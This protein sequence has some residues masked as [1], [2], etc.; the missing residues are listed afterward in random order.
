[1][2]PKRVFIDGYPIADLEYCACDTEKS[3]GIECI[4]LRNDD[5]APKCKRHEYFDKDLKLVVIPSLPLGV[6]DVSRT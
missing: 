2:N 6:R 1:M 4:G 3:N 5:V